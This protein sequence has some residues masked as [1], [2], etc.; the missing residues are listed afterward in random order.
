MC[1]AHRGQQRALWNWSEPPYRCWELYS[2]P[3]QERPILP[4]TEPSLQAILRFWSRRRWRERQNQTGLSG[5]PF[6][7][8]SFLWTIE[9]EISLHPSSFEAYHK[10][11]GACSSSRPLPLN[12]RL[13]HFSFPKCQS[14]SPRGTWTDTAKFPRSTLLA[15]I[16][17][18][19]FASY[20]TSAQK[21]ITPSSLGLWVCL[22]KGTYIVSS[23]GCNLRAQLHAAVCS[24]LKSSSLRPT[25]RSQDFLLFV[26]P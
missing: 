21:P 6:H 18:H 9:S 15:V 17:L 8:C 5:L 1:N 26:S 3:R 12:I 10:I 2:D 25:Q 16:R 7:L 22:S 19:P 11:S 14:G 24:R 13:W 23:S 20:H 4:N